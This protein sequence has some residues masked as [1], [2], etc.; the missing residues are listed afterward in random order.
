VQQ[1]NSSPQWFCIVV[2]VGCHR[3]VRAMLADKGYRCFVP[4][5]LVWVTH[6][7]V[8]QAKEKPLLG[9]YVFV[10]LDPASQSFK[11]VTKTP[12]VE[13]VISKAPRVA[14]HTPTAR[15]GPL[16]GVKLEF[17]NARRGRGC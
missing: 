15:L 12:G 3:R 17:R 14:G 8:K 11:P 13:A 4:M 6:A 5:K 9:R 10:E 16:H 1:S 7:R 2:E